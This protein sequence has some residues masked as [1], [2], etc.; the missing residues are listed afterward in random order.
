M[1]AQAEYRRQKLWT[2]LAAGACLGAGLVLA[3]S[4]SGTSSLAAPLIRTGLVLGPLWLALPRRRPD[5][6]WSRL[7]GVSV[8]LFM[9]AVAL[10][11]YRPLYFLPLF[12]VLL[13]LS[14]FSWGPPP[15]PPQ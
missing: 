6:L 9:A 15:K 11:A 14:A 4:T 5:R 7:T 8:L 2:G 10:F 1:D 13:V 3:Y 12:L